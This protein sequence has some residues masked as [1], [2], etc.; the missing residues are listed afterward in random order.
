MR[1]M[2]WSIQMI[3]SKYAPIVLTSLHACAKGMGAYAH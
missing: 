3:Y 1:H 2:Q